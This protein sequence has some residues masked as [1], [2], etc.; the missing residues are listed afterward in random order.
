MMGPFKQL[1]IWLK[2]PEFHVAAATIGAAVVGGVASNMA[3]DSAAGAQSSA[4]NQAG[5]TS[6]AQYQQTRQD[7]MPFLQ[8]GTA[9]S[10]ALAYRLGLNPLGAPGSSNANMPSRNDI[11]NQYEQELAQ[12]GV[13]VPYSQLTPVDQAR[14]DATVDQRYNAALQTAQQAALPTAQNDPTFGSLLNGFTQNDLNNDVVYNTGLQFGLDQGT[15]GINNQAAATGSM[16]SG[17]TLKALAQYGNDYGN[18]K[19]GDAF[20]R[21]NTQ[22]TNVFNRLSGVAGSGQQAVQNVDSA[23]SQAASSI[24]SNQVGVG[25]AR[26][27]SA[28]AG[29]NAFTNGINNAVNNY[30]SNAFLSRF[31]DPANSVNYG[32]GKNYTGSTNGGYIDGPANGSF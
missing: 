9:A 23:G 27:A 1:M 8:N 4:A 18:Q 5:Q 22:N 14:R 28:I 31:A 17:A 7:N 10:N 3:S 25:N 16:L 11:F 24:A 12:N 13:D 19:A 26:G 32:V 2:P 6:W 30:Q 21:W 15:K 29:G 20:N